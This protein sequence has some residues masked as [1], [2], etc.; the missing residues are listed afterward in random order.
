M[1]LG[2]GVGLCAPSPPV[3]T[4]TT[5]GLRAVGGRSV[6]SAVQSPGQPHEPQEQ[7]ELHFEAPGS[8]GRSGGRGIAAAPPVP[9]GG[10]PGSG[11]IFS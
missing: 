8:V 4:A 7:P 1:E 10:A 6:C 2:R 3:A 5:A 11:Q 9:A